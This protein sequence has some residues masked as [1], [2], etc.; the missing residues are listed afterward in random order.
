VSE[1]FLARW[2]RLKA[3]ARRDDGGSAASETAGTVTAP[4]APEP[5][6]TAEEIAALP[7][8]EELTAE[9]EITAFLRRG[10]PTPLRNAALR[11]AWALDPAIRDFPGHARDYAYDWN[12]PGGVPGSGAFPP[13]EDMTA[14]VRTV[15]GE[16]HADSGTTPESRTAAA[17]EEHSATSAS[18]TGSCAS[19]SN[20]GAAG[21]VEE[22][23]SDAATDGPTASGKETSHA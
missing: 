3:A 13:G 15:L 18:K 6:I 5:E 23:A 11:K 7:K 1:A 16:Q 20:R 17:V 10:V 2:S 12:A 9:T 4:A 8:I 21:P 19:S 14:M 22:E